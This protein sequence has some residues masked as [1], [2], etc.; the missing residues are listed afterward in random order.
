MNRGMN[1]KQE[2]FMMIAALVAAILVPIGFGWYFHEGGWAIF[3]MVILSIILLVTL[4][5]AQIPYIGWLVYIILNTLLTIP[6]FFRYTGLQWTPLIIGM[7]VLYCLIAIVIAV[8]KVSGA[9][10]YEGFE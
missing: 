8:L 5:V 4:E 2:V 6:Q 1:K 3:D 10:D 7:L 9:T